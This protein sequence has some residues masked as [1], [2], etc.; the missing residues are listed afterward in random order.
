MGTLGR[1]ESQFKGLLLLSGQGVLLY[2]NMFNDRL[3]DLGMRVLAPGF[4]HFYET[5]LA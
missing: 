4:S 1:H 3:S 2:Q 5:V